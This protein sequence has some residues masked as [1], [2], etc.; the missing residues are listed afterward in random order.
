[1]HR[2]REPDSFRRHGAEYRS[3]HPFA[4]SPGVVPTRMYIEAGFEAALSTVELPKTVTLY[5]TSGRADW[6]FGKSVNSFVL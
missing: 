3:V 6:L 5:L 1:M 2:H 4:L